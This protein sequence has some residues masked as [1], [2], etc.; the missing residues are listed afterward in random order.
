MV[1]SVGCSVSKQ[2]VPA[3]T[4]PSEFGTSIVL[5]A[6]PEVLPQDGVS[7]SRVTATVRDTAGLPKRDVVI[8]WS[9]LTSDSDSIP[10]SV[11]LSA[12]VSKTDAVGYATG[13]VTAPRRPA[14]RPVA[15]DTISVQAAPESGDAAAAFV[16]FVTIR[17]QPPTDT[18]PAT[19]GLVARFTV[20]PTQPRVGA[21]VTFDASASTTLDNTVIT[22][23]EW[24]F[25]DGTGDITT[26]PTT[27]HVYTEDRV[28]PTTLRITNNV[29]SS[30]TVGRSLTVLP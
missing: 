16:R 3:L 11:A 12:T 15:P 19:F 28:Y 14:Q 24:S 20:T 1:G 6:S 7:Q 10:T 17:L 13:V 27:S 26:T 29:G 23:Y 21:D 2:D 9:A 18:P 25:G 5:S 22:K 30:Q 4:G 8:R